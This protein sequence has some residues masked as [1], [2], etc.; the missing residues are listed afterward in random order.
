M[1]RPF[2]DEAVDHAHHLAA[3]GSVLDEDTVESLSA[4]I[5]SRS[6]F[7]Y[8]RPSRGLS[9]RLLWGALPAAQPELLAQ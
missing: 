4:R 8:R 9:G 6:I 1:H 5:W 2:V 3:R 7:A